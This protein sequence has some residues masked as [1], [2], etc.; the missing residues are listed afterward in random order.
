MRPTAVGV[1][2]SSGLV[3]RTFLGEQRHQLQARDERSQKEY[4]RFEISMDLHGTMANNE[5]IRREMGTGPLRRVGVTGTD[6]QVYTYA[7]PSRT[8]AF[9]QLLR[10]GTGAQQ[11]AAA[12]GRELLVTS[13][14]RDASSFSGVSLDHSPIRGQK[15]SIVVR[16]SPKGVPLRMIVTR[17]GQDVSRSS[18]VDFT[19][20]T[21]L[22]GL[23]RRTTIRLG[24][25]SPDSPSAIDGSAPW[26]VKVI[27]LD[28]GPRLAQRSMSVN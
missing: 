28:Q 13:S 24:H 8:S 16:A 22:E 26:I 25:A 10:E 27:T 14:S 20:S 2:M 11:T 6:S 19:D 18:V 12:A 7:A 21:I 5:S 3:A 1:N 23:S 9:E 4:S 17:A 15:R